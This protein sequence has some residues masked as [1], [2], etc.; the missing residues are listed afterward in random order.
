MKYRTVRDK[1]EWGDI[2]ENQYFFFL[3]SFYEEEDN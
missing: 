2:V 3:S 1:V